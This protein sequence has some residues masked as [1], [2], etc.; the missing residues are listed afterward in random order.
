MTTR[1]LNKTWRDVIFAQYTADYEADVP[2]P[3]RYLINVRTYNNRDILI[4]IPQKIDV[5][6]FK[7]A[8]LAFYIATRFGEPRWKN[9]HIWVEP[10]ITYAE[11]QAASRAEQPK[12]N[13]EENEEGTGHI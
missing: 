4:N 6:T 11:K 3:V 9:E 5:R 7:K 1:N 13:E 2:F 10:R 12:E 8:V